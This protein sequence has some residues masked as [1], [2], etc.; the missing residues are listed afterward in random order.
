MMSYQDIMDNYEFCSINNAE[1]A[2]EICN[3]FVVNFLE[4]QKENRYIERLD[5][6]DYTRNFCHWLF[7]KGH[8]QSKL[9]MTN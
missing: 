8:T 1:V 6:I 3:E 2:P 9:T 4:K 7:I 5:A